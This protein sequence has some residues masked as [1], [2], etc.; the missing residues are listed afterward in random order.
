MPEQST[1]SGR[2]GRKVA[3]AGLNVE[4]DALVGGP[5]V[6]LHAVHDVRRVAHVPAEQLG[7][8]PRAGVQEVA[9][10]RELHLRAG[11]ALFFVIS[12]PCL[13]LLKCNI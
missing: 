11:A 8:A 6:A 2:A 5:S 12:G 9:V 4:L 7:V 13:L 3:A 10:R 1:D